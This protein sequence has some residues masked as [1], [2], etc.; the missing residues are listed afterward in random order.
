L[1]KRTEKLFPGYGCYDENK[2]GKLSYGRF[3]CSL[4]RE[5][6]KEPHPKHG[7]AEEEE[8]G[9]D[10]TMQHDLQLELEQMHGADKVF[11]HQPKIPVRQGDD[12]GFS[13]NYELLRHL[14]S[15]I[16]LAP[17]TSTPGTAVK[18]ES[19]CTSSSIQ[20]RRP[21]T[22]SPNK[23]P[24]IQNY[25]EPF[26]AIMLDKSRAPVP[27][28]IVKTLL[29]NKPKPTKNYAG[30]SKAD[31]TKD[32]HA[33]YISWPENGDQQPPFKSR[34]IVIPNSSFKGQLIRFYTS[35]SEFKFMYN[36]LQKA[37]RNARNSWV[38]HSHYNLEIYV[39]EIADTTY[40]SL[41]HRIVEMP[42]K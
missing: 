35:Y 21:K 6:Q 27:K 9:D 30:S 41:I 23:L 18:E 17:A 33:Y 13:Q 10:E 31:A 15:G 3:S 12:G 4:E 19:N 32:M 40:N 28:I 1:N 2:D 11:L 24:H 38:K 5:L 7:N 25:S 26:E 36:H 8:G 42:N 39:P 37:N 20:K 14:C 29:H 22:P 34:K 16:S